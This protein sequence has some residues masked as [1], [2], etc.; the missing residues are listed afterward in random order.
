[1]LNNFFKIAFRNFS[2]FKI[3]T[4]VNI[5]GFA[6]GLAS[7]IIILLYVANELS[8]DRFHSNADRIYRVTINGL[9][10]G[11][12]FHHAV[13]APPM[14][15]ALVDDLPE[16]IN[17]VRLQPSE[18][19]L[20]RTGEEIFIENRFLWA[21]STFFEVFSFPLIIGNPETVLDEHHTV[22]LTRKLAMKYFG[23]IDCAGEMLEFEDF[24]PYKVAGVCED[25][26]ENSHFKFDILASLSSL[27]YDK[28][29]GWLNHTFHTYILLDKNVDPNQLE[30][31]FDGIIEKYVGPQLQSIL[32]ASLKE[33][34]AGGGIYEY[35]IQPLTDI[36]L[37][38][39]LEYEI[40]ANGNITYIYMFSIIAL[41][42]LIIACINF[43]NLSTARSTTR[44][45][46]VGIRKVMGSNIAQLIRQFLS[47]SIM[48]T[49]IAMAFAL[50]MAYLT[51]PFFNSI[52]GRQIELSLLGEWYQIPLI[53]LV[54]IVV[55]T[56]AGIYPAFYLS[57]FQ[58]AK[59]LKTSL[60]SGSTKGLMLRNGLVVVQFSISIFLFI[61]TLVVWN[62]LNYIHEKNLGWDKDHIFVIKRAWAIENN[63]EA[64][65]S[66]LLNNPNI[67][68]FS[69][70][71]S[72]PGRGTGST[73]FRNAE[74]PRAEQHLL[75]VTSAKYNLDK[76]FKFDFVDGRFFSKEHPSDS[77]TVVINEAAAETL[78]LEDPVGKK[79]VLV[80]ASPEQD[81]YFAV[82]GVL[83]DYHYESFHQKIRPLLYFLE[84]DW[85]AFMTM[86]ISPKNVKQTIAYI[87]QTWTKYIPSKPIEYFFIDDDFNKLYDA[88]E[89]TSKIFS[90]FSLLAILIA[91]LGLFGMATFTTVQRTKEIGIRKA[92]GASIPKI[93]Y[94]L[95]K[96]FNKWVLFANVLAW[97]VAFYFMQK[98]LENFE[99]RIDLS[100][101][102]FLI[103][104]LSAFAIAIITVSYQ[105]F[106]AAIISS[107][108]SLRQE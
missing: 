68:T 86:R 59:V 48:L 60:S 74:A 7:C 77:N 88:E 105:T 99:Y 9:V 13:S 51:L 95:L 35:R 93:V 49:A 107:A 28:S 61:S 46:E 79:I 63:E 37:K 44:A 16:V 26:P 52:A 4:F 101:S 27:G 50:L 82:I 11:N 106:K 14:A 20:I 56:I 97:P 19:M 34:E 78:G 70:S 2:R 91:C 38:S 47:E 81:I 71:S 32:G 72:I 92:L 31:K 23:R 18:N 57:S 84:R 40:E 45:R 6:V 67:F 36:H 3:Y 98:W 33:L 39:N 102:S 75:N 89:R 85:P 65:G 58:P 69:S 53:V 15:K 66:E 30:Q 90:S 104:G 55:G 87:E 80:G 54:V 10:G 103:A 8:Y 12:E 29:Q 76:T 73:V 108:E 100:F 42:I 5:T 25:P 24:T 41:F 62:Q 96:D 17:A 1:M 22:V 94:M 83:K 43:M 64:F 21:D